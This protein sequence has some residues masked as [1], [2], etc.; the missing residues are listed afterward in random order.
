MKLLNTQYLYINSANRNA[1]EEVCS[2]S[3]LFNN[4]D[5]ACKKDE[6]MKVGVQSFDLYH[7]WTYV[8]AN[9]NTFQLFEVIPDS[10]EYVTITIPEGN[11]TFKQ[12]AAK[13]TSL[14]EKWTVTWSAITNKFTFVFSTLHDMLPSSAYKILGLSNDTSTRYSDLLTLDS[15]NVLRPTL[16][17]RINVHIDNL[18]PYQKI[19]LENTLGSTGTA[20]TKVLSIVNNFSP[21]DVITYENNSNM[22]S[23]FVSEK[24][25]QKIQI[26]LRD[27]DGQLL[28]FVQE[29]Y[30][31]V[32]KVET[33]Q[34]DSV[35][36]NETN[37]MISNLQGIKE[38]LRLMFV[39]SNIGR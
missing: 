34:D 14:Y 38:Y 33:Y 19:N 25:I 1:N 22:Y 39:S 2:F 16:S 5:V 8:N 3:V 23:F 4:G 24:D 26:S 11:Y 6:V 15:V 35:A 9:N 10:I 7:T 29:D 27:V 32:L 18:T 37:N 30:N 36:D 21:F 28:N 13:L 17:E 31:I 20:S 12:L